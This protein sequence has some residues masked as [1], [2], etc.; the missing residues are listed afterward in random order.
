MHTKKQHN[1]KMYHHIKL[2]LGHEYN[3]SMAFLQD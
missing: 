2:N 3:G 1:R